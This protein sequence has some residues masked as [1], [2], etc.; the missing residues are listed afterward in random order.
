MHD[1]IF[2]LLVIIFV[3]G[4]TIRK[5]QS[6]RGLASFL[7]SIKIAIGCLYGRRVKKA[8]KNMTDSF[9]IILPR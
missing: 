4:L 8:K 6:F 7:G 9:I 5:K 1:D 2:L 3:S